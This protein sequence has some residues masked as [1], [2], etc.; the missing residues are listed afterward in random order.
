MCYGLPTHWTLTLL[1]GLVA[2][3]IAVT[4][5]VSL[6]KVSTLGIGPDG[7][8]GIGLVVIIKVCRVIPAVGQIVSIVIRGGVPIRLVGAI[9]TSCLVPIRLVGAIIETS[10]P[11]P[12]CLIIVGEVYGRPVPLRWTCANKVE[13]QDKEDS[14]TKHGDGKVMSSKIDP[15]K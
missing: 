13:Q 6:A 4:I 7:G 11:V 8:D 12:I 15:N 10:C 9:G 5:I 2:V 3:C 14:L 1:Q